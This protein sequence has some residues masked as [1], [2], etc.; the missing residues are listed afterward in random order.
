MAAFIALSSSSGV[1]RRCAIT[2]R[3]VLYIHFGPFLFVFDWIV[4]CD[5]V[6]RGWVSGGLGAADLAEHSYHFRKGSDDFVG[7]LEDLPRPASDQ[8]PGRWSHVKQIAS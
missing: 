7:L 4:V 2:L 1:R 5:H 3:S 6:H 8:C